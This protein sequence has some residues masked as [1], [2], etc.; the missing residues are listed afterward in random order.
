[1]LDH[2]PVSMYEK[3]KLK[4]VFF[5]ELPK[6]NKTDIINNEEL[7]EKFI[8]KVVLDQSKKGNR[9]VCSRR[10]EHLI[11][12]RYQ[13]DDK[14]VDFLSR[15]LCWL[16]ENRMNPIEAISHPWISEHNYNNIR[17]SHDNNINNIKIPTIR[18]DVNIDSSVEMD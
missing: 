18:A 15:C 4:E 2:P 3:C 6:N 11:N 14:F 7:S 5:E 10:I 8:P 13:S 17:K 1:M 12:A 9:I 16:P